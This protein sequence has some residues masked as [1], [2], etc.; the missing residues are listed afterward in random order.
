MIEFV[1]EQGMLDQG[2][3][4]DRLKSVVAA[5]ELEGGL[6]IKI[7]DKEES[8][9]LNV[10]YRQ[11]DYATDVLSFPFNEELP[12]GG[13]YL[14]DIFICHPVALEQAQEGGIPVEKELFTLM[15]HGILHLSGHDHEIDTGEMTALQEQLVQEHF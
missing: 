5:L 13:Y 6:V 12:G 4:L 9:Q 10:T 15:V 8:R 1:D 2:F 7:G 11:K 3:F 14:G